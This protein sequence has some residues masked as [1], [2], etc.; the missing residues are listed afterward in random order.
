MSMNLISHIENSWCYPPSLTFICPGLLL[1]LLSYSLT[2]S[3]FSQCYEVELF[4][5]DLVIRFAS[6]FILCREIISMCMHAVLS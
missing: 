4:T 5:S 3:L 6:R 1:C 2:Q